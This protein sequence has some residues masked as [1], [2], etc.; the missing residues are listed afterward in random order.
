MHACGIFGN[1]IIF[2]SLKHKEMKQ[3]DF[4]YTSTQNLIVPVVGDIIEDTDGGL[5]LVVGRTLK[6]NNVLV[7]HTEKKEG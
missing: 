5:W 7:V 6:P 3:Q 2:A 4:H 1:V